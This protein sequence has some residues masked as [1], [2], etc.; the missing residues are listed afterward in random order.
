MFKI[1]FKYYYFPLFIIGKTHITTDY[2]Q[3][4]KWVVENSEKQGYANK[5]ADIDSLKHAIKIIY[6]HL[7]TQSWGTTLNYNKDNIQIS[8]TIGS[9][10][11]DVPLTMFFDIHIR[12]WRKGEIA[13][14]QY[15]EDSL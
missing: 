7:H 15:K 6:K 10:R 11:G 12:G 8:A 4:S 1:K 3:I 14:A 5:I 9:K 13:V 2:E